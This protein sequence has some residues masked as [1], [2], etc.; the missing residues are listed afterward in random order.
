MSR[1][2]Q[3]VTI[4]WLPVCGIAQTSASQPAQSRIAHYDGAD[5]HL[6]G[7]G[8]VCCPCSVP[9]PCRTNASATYGHCEATLYL[10]V[11]EGHYG[12]IGL[13]GL[14]VVDTSGACGMNY[15][16]LAAVYFD[17]SAGPAAEEAFLKVLASFL[18]TQTA[19]FP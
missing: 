2:L 16:K 10:H 17:R 8:V 4:L 11:R 14:R 7:E 3:F 19:E 1:I 5:W 6:K 15:E 9:C 12:S 18:S 13:S